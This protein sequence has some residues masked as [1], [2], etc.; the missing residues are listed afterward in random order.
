MMRIA[1]LASEYPAPS[2]TFIRREIA[3]LRRAGLAVVTFSIRPARGE[4]ASDQERADRAETQAVL[5]RS[6]FAYAGALASALVTRPARTLG[7]LGLALRHRAPG[8]R[9]LVWALFHFVEAVLL[10]GLLRRGGVTRLHSHF[11]N[12]GA[13]VGLLAANIAG[14]PWSMTLHGVSETDYPAGLMLADKVRRADFVA[15]A[16]W[17]MRAQAMR[18]AAPRDWPRLHVVRCGIDPAAMP[19]AAAESDEAVKFVCVGRLSREKGQRGLLEAFAAVRDAIPRARL[20]LVGDGPLRAELEALARELDI[21]AAVRF[22]GALSEADTLARIAAVDVLV[23]P[24]FMEGLP[25]VIMEAMA[26]GRPV[27]A[28]GVAGIPELVKHGDNGI[29]VPPSNW[30][31]LGQA[32][33]ALARD[34]DERRRLGTAARAAVMDEFAIDRAVRPLIALLTSG[35]G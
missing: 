17:F 6:P 9:A 18:V 16:S 5:G 32:M 15:C 12:S 27:I 34:G 24:S 26:L 28:S 21:A 13:T 7:A 10:A 23:L 1:Y 33:I 35:R 31:A 29:L 30:S 2:H 14:I 20:D 4:P 25:L 19:Q 8:A 11:A 22:H 3:A